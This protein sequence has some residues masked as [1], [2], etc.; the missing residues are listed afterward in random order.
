MVASPGG[1]DCAASLARTGCRP[2]RPA[3]ASSPDAPAQPGPDPQALALRRLLRRGA[4]ALRRPRPDRPARPVL[5]GALGSR[6][7]SQLRQDEAAAGQPGG[8]DGRFPDRDRS[9][10][11]AGKPGPRRLSPDRD[12]LPQRLG[13]GLD[14]KALGGSDQRHDRDGGEAL[15]GRRPRRRRPVGRLPAATHQLALVGGHR[16][17]DGRPLACLEPGRGDQRPGRRAASGR[18]GSTGRRSSRPRSASRG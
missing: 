3:T 13:L 18:S 7:R 1:P 17:G 4:D 10:R 2:S 15:A 9:A 5:L 8:A 14:P 16:P 11:A 12:D 6:G